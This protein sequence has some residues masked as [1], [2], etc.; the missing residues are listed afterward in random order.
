MDLDERYKSVIEWFE[1]NMPLAVSELSYESPFQ[2]L[3]AVILSA[4]CTDKRVN[5]VTKELFKKYSSPES[6]ASATPEEVFRYISSVTYPNSKSKHLVNMSKMIVERFDSKVPSDPLLL[7]ELPGVG[8]KTANVVASIAYGKPVIAVDTHVFRISR[9]LGLSKS[10]T[11]YGVEQDLSAN[12]PEDKRA[13]A[14]HWLILHGRYI[15]VARN[16]KCSVCGLKEWCLHYHVQGSTDL[17]ISS[18]D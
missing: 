10:K 9:R 2:L 11:P 4:Q 16:P 1:K 5:M 18:T 13:I 3:V 8:R 14:H 15:C 7:K 6:L 17:H 12:I